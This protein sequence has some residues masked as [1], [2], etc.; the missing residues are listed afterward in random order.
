MS[1]RRLLV[2]AVFVVTVGHGGRGDVAR[3]AAA[4]RADAAPRWRQSIRPR[5]EGL[6]ATVARMEQRLAANPDDG[7]AVV[8]LAQA[9]IRVQRVDSDA[10]AVV[11]AEQHLRAFLSRSPD[12]YEAQQVLGAVLLSQHRFRDAIREA[13]RARELDPRDTFNDGVIGDASLELGDY[14][15]R[16]RGVRSDGP[17]AA[18]TA[19][20]RARG[21]CA[22]DARRARRG[23]REHA[24]GV[25]RH[26]RK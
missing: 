8:R 14:D 26:E 9:L 6:K 25:R 21:V 23:A 13:E 22:G 3:R 1:R 15:R 18:R 7:D 24:H 5:R 10:P 11:K 4:G 12:R 19:G 16:V 20:L 2:P 17:A